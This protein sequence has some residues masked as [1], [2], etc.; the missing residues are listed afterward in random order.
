LLGVVFFR[1]RVEFGETEFDEFPVNFQL[2]LIA[3]IQQHA[4][5]QGK[6]LRLLKRY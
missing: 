1:I 3:V 2:A 6:P 4:D 5:P